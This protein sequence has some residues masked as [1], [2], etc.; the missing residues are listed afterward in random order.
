VVKIT[1]LAR[2]L[3]RK[4]DS[5]RNWIEQGVIPPAPVRLVGNV[6]ARRTGRRAASFTAINDLSDRYAFKYES[7]A[8]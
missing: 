4:T 5:I 3:E 1:E 2:S 6:R 8:R 7:K